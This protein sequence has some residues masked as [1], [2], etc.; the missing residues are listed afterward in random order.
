MDT[1]NY[2]TT[3]NDND[4]SLEYRREIKSF[5]GKTFYNLFGNNYFDDK[6]VHSEFVPLMNI[7]FLYCITITYSSEYKKTMTTE[8]GRNEVMASIFVGLNEELSK[9][10]PDLPTSKHIVD[11]VRVNEL[12]ASDDEI[13]THALV[14]IHPQLL[15]KVARTVFWYLKGLSATQIRGV[16]EIH[17]QRITDQAGIVSYICKYEYGKNRDYKHFVF[18]PNFKRLAAKH[19]CSRFFLFNG[20]RV[21][22]DSYEDP[23]KSYRE[24]DI[25]VTMGYEPMLT[26][27]EN[28]ITD[29]GI[30]PFDA[31]RLSHWKHSTATPYRSSVPAT[32][33]HSLQNQSSHNQLTLSFPAFYQPT[34]SLE[35]IH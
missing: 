29:A 7:P 26:G 15:T 16:K 18:S 4:A 24:A 10:H 2:T 23:Y 9:A 20:R 14:H 6:R 25:P 30:I 31:V 8:R 22:M 3:T 27:M 34:P 19:H 17:V 12:G 28:L 1:N 32:A 21:E 11:Y 13:H 33:C 5:N 35:G